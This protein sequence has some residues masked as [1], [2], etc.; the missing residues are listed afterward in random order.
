MSGTGAHFLLVPNRKSHEDS[1]IQLKFFAIEN[2]VF[3]F[4][5]SHFILTMQITVPP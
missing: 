4:P 2:S 3:S 5:V 1:Q